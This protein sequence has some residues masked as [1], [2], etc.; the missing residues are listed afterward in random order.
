MSKK[1]TAQIPVHQLISNMEGQNYW[2]NGCIEFLMECLHEDKAYDYWFFSGV[3][4][5]SFTQIFSKKPENMT[6]CYSDS[7][8]AESVKR[9]FYACGYNYDYY[10]D[11]NEGCRKE[12][13]RRIREYIDKNIPVIARVNDVFHSYAIICGYDDSALY[14]ILGENKEPA[15]YTY[16]QLLF[17]TDKKAK[18]PLADVYKES[19]MRIPSIFSMAETD[20][21]SFGK[22]AFIDWAE[23]LTDG[24]YDPIPD[25]DKLWHT[26]ESPE[27]CCWNMHGTYLCILGTNL[28]AVEFLKEALRLNPDMT[29]IN[30]LLPLFDKINHDG[31]NALI[32]A[33]GGFH[34]KPE[35]FKNKTKMKP[36]RD[37]IL[38]LLE[39]CDK[40]LDVFNTL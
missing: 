7:F 10:D 40:I 6:L 17:V 32:G 33:E 13:D 8:P 37:K 24:R 38:A 14:Y 25:N 15:A 12:L 28:C 26:H 2:L 31:F 23:S 30:R 36:L 18:P 20:E 27:F 16:D 22:Q 35:V 39:Y 9:A 3:T 1:L 5:D 4:G 21:Y 29:F 19:V 11:I 34:M